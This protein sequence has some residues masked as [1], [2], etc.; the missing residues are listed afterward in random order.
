L[1]N[2]EILGFGFKERGSLMPM[3]VTYLPELK[4]ALEWQAYCSKNLRIISK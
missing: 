4:N 3:A 1:V 2:S